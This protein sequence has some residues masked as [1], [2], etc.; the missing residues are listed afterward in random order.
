VATRRELFRYAG[1]HRGVVHDLTFHPNG[2]ALISA[3]ADGEIRTWDLTPK[4]VVLRSNAEI[5]IEEERY[6]AR[7]WATLRTPAEQRDEFT[8]VFLSETGKELFARSA[9]GNIWNWQT[10]ERAAPKIVFDGDNGVSAYGSPCAVSSDGKI[11]AVTPQ[12]GGVRLYDSEVRGQ[13]DNQPGIEEAISDLYFTP[14]TARLSIVTVSGRLIYWDCRTGKEVPRAPDFKPSLG[15]RER[16][17]LTFDGDEGQLEIWDTTMGRVIRHL[18]NLGGPLAMSPDGRYVV[19]TALDGSATIS[20]TSTMLCVHTF[21]PQGPYQSVSFSP[22]G[23]LVAMGYPNGTI[24][25]WDIRALSPK[26]KSDPEAIQSAWKELAS[27]ENG[28]PFKAMGILQAAPTETLA[29][30]RDKLR[31]AD[32]M[33]AATLTKLFQDLDHDRFAVRERATKR[34]IEIADTIDG[35]IQRRRARASAE[36]SWRL[37]RVLMSK[38]RLIAD[39]EVLRRLRAIEVLERIGSAEA[40]TLLKK[41]AEGREGVFERSARDALA[42]LEY[43]LRSKPD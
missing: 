1:G 19:H 28:I 11:I 3:G 8:K 9:T 39:G 2:K 27:T 40:R 13:L 12:E 14:N 24:L 4:R 35:E 42:R 37:E 31:S 18:P 25:L 15:Q 36:A 38:A 23:K 33:D 6:S 7:E 22:D 21:N 34:L 43:Q 30:F 10:H 5:R 16:Y 20:E 41:L 17:R 32:A 26:S 29:L